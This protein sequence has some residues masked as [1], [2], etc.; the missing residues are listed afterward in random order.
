MYHVKN[1]D[2]YLGPLAKR[3]KR[4]HKG[5]INLI[6]NFVSYNRH[7]ETLDAI[8]NM[9]FDDVL[10][11]GSS[12]IMSN[13]GYY[14]G[15]TNEEQKTFEDLLSKAREEIRARMNIFEKDQLT[16]LKGK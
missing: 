12:C 4:I 13:I 9:L 15:L 8:D 10:Y 16:I 7:M 3:L 11:Y 14:G 1:E 5:D 2:Q 6:E